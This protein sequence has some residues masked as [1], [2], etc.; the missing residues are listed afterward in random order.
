MPDAYSDTY[1][2]DYGVA[3]VVVSSPPITAVPITTSGRNLKWHAVDSLTGRIVGRLNPSRWEIVEPLRSPATGTLTVPV[4]DDPVALAQLRQC[5]IPQIRSVV[6]EDDDGTLIFGGPIPYREG[7]AGGELTIPLVDWRAWFYTVPIRPTS[8]GARHDYIVTA[9]EQSLIMTDLMSLALTGTGIPLMVVDSAPTTGVTRDL[10]AKMFQTKV[11][12]S[13]DTILN[14]ERGAEW[15]TYPTRTSP[16]MVLFH[17]AVA[18]PERQTRIDPIR[19]SWRQDVGGN[20][21]EV[22][23][24]VASEASPSKVW[25]V[26]GGSDDV[27][28]WSSAVDPGV[29][30]GSRLL[31]ESQLTL[32]DGTT[33]KASAFEAAY[34]AVTRASSGVA[35]EAEFTI[36]LG[37]RR[38]TLKDGTPGNRAR[39]IFDNGWQAFDLPACRITQRVMSGG[40]GQPTQQ[41]LTLDLTDSRYPDDGGDPGRAVIDDG[42]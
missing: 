25:A 37:S 19:V 27:A 28:L 18:W 34:G 20:A 9:R 42:S 17:V 8:G 12:E 41:R 40:R 31:W 6:L 24:P 32:N 35:G 1:T 2:D 33:S 10:T 14:R 23:W 22:S 38:P 7:Y 39:L 36:Q 3:S 30:A 26:D 15:W 29:A 13:L 4:P 11:G 21:S 5:V 16:T